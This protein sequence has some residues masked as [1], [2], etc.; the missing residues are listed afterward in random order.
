MRIR[1]VC[2]RLLI[3]ENHTDNDGPGQYGEGRKRDRTWDPGHW[4]RSNEPT[5]EAQ[6]T[7]GARSHNQEKL[8][9][10]TIHGPYL[11]GLSLLWSRA[12]LTRLSASLFRSR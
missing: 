2:E 4:R 8:D 1:E 11:L 5:N 7:T 12:S 3:A 10:P 6:G 9:T